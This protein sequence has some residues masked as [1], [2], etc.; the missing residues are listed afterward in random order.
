[1]ELGVRRDYA[2]DGYRALMPD[3][4]AIEA[5]SL[6]CFRAEFSCLATVL[7]YSRIRL[8]RAETLEEADF[9]LTATGATVLLSDVLFL[10][11][12][13]HE[14]LRMAADTRPLTGCVVVTERADW[15]LAVDVYPFGGCGVL[16]K[17]VDP[18]EAIRLI[19]TVDQAARDRRFLWRQYALLPVDR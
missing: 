11:G 12:A 8:H 14:A 17:P 15:P 9:L 18:I 4:D 2:Q 3:G 1:M 16:G 19:R 6:T 7:Q 10:D 13:W 5:V